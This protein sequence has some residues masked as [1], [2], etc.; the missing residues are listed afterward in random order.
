MLLGAACASRLVVDFQMGKLDAQRTPPVGRSDADD[1]A[2]AI[3]SEIRTEAR[4]SG[5]IRGERLH[6]RGPA[7]LELLHVAR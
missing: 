6:L 5:R 7:L 3:L 2:T 4:A 1:D